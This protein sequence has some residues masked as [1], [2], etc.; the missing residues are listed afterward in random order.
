[1]IGPL[2]AQM[3]AR[4]APTLGYSRAYLNLWPTRRQLS[5]PWKTLEQSIYKSLDSLPVLFTEAGS[6]SWLP[7]AEVV[8]AKEADAR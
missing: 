5:E 1:M 3:I 6:G 8:F 2:Y 7:A 4:A